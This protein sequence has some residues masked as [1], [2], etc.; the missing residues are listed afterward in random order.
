MIGTTALRIEEAAAAQ[1]QAQGDIAAAV[2]LLIVA[3]AGTWFFSSAA[4][5][6]KRMPSARKPP[7]FIEDTGHCGKP[8]RSAREARAISQG[9]V[10][11]RSRKEKHVELIASRI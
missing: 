4:T 3:G 11:S 1:E 5:P 10:V 9:K 2:V 6:R 7:N 8:R